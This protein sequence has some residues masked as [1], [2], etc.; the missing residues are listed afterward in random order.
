MKFFIVALIL[1]LWL[2]ISLAQTSQEIEELQQSILKT[3]QDIEK[4]NQLIQQIPSD[5]PRYWEAE[6]QLIFLEILVD[7]LLAQLKKAESGA[8][9]F[10]KKTSKKKPAIPFENASSTNQPPQVWLGISVEKIPESLRKIVGLPENTGLLIQSVQPESPA[11]KAG[12]QN[13]DILLAC[14]GI[15]IQ[16]L[17]HFGQI[18]RQKQPHDLLTVKVLQK[19]TTSELDLVLGQKQHQKPPVEAQKSEVEDFLEGVFTEGEMAPKSNKTRKQ[20]N[21]WPP[22]KKLAPDL[23]EEFTQSKTPS[24]PDASSNDLMNNFFE[25]LVQNPES[26]KALL[27]TAEKGLEQFLGKDQKRLVKNLR[28][29]AESFMEDFEDPE[30]RDRFMEDTEVFTKRFLGK[31]GTLSPEI[32]ESLSEFFG[33]EPSEAKKT[34]GEFNADYFLEQI[35][36]E[37]PKELERLLK[38]LG[39]SKQSAGFRRFLKRA[40]ANASTRKKDRKKL[41]E[42]IDDLFEDLSSSETESKTPSVSTKKASE[43]RVEKLPATAETIPLLPATPKPYLGFKLLPL[44]PIL[45]TQL[46][47]GEN[48]GVLVSQVEDPGP[49]AIA[50][51]QKGDVLLAIQ[52]NPISSL[53][54][55]AKLLRNR[56]AG[57]SLE[58]KLNRKGEGITLQLLLGT[59]TE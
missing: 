13:L 6:K 21:A 47:L 17:A 32:Q 8:T 9:S 20:E 54:D 15:E 41:N 34:K 3:R 27:D 16:S 44:S 35:L 37:N 49:A 39:N 55:V 1:S 59:K 24:D 23:L 25:E 53:G 30:Q 58:M 11:E 38:Q 56:S 4:Q 31:D 43:P 42:E 45:R 33:D 28:K 52:G 29:Q 14:D 10:S 48:E 7:E 36:A 40:I 57:E 2:G 51:I 22:K 50:G 5:S 26:Q 46:D 12:L 19:G 18:I